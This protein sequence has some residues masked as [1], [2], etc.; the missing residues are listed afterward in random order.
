MGS[1]HFGVVDISH[2]L[3]AKPNYLRFLRALF[4]CFEVVS[5]L[6]INLAKSKLV[7]LGN[8]ENVDGLVGILV[9]GKRDAL[10]TTLPFVKLRTFYILEEAI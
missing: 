4:L 7:T 3:W 6:K 8:V 5:D 9:C 10:G 1:R 2:L